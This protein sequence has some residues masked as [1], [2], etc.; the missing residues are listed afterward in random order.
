MPFSK[1]LLSPPTSDANANR[2]STSSV[3]KSASVEFKIVPRMGKQPLVLPPNSSEID[4]ECKP[5][6]IRTNP[7]ISLTQ[8]NPIFYSPAAGRGSYGSSTPVRSQSTRA[9]SSKDSYR[10]PDIGAPDIT[11]EI[12]R[13]ERRMSGT[14]VAPHKTSSSSTS[15][16]SSSHELKLSMPPALEGG[17][18][19]RSSAKNVFYTHSMKKKSTEPKFV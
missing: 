18:S 12:M 14:F 17:S 9:P 1:P 16:S 19:P 15:M 10:L 8:S 3:E 5:T 4:I 2:L 6:P 11:N 7:N 13:N